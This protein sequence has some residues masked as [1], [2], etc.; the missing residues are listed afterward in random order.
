MTGIEMAIDE[1]TD[2]LLRYCGPIFVAPALNSYPEQMIASG[3]YALIDTDQKRFLVT[4]CHVWDKY[5]EQHDANLETILAVA[6]G[7]GKSVIAFKNPELH[8]LAVNRDLDLAVFEFG[9]NEIPVQ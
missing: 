9:P 1:I 6:L 2:E 8:K 5:V 3:T 7:E 4:C